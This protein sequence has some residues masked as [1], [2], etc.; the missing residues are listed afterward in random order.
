[1]GYNADMIAAAT[2]VAKQLHGI[3]S[4]VDGECYNASFA[5]GIRLAAS[6]IPSKM[7]EGELICK[8]DRKRY[9]H[10]WS[11]VTGYIID[12]TAGQ[13]WGMPNVVI[14]LPKDLPQY[15][16]IKEHRP[17]FER[18]AQW[19]GFDVCEFSELA[20]RRVPLWQPIM[21]KSLDKMVSS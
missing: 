5:L 17:D 6:G 13:F 2:E 20:T 9:R 14:G 4:P 21:V 10:F 12:V 11:Q 3:V 19:L 1:M 15:H 16:S 18:I 8:L 7:I